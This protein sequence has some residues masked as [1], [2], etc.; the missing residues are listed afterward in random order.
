MGGGALF[1]RLSAQA[2]TTPVS[3]KPGSGSDG[4]LAQVVLG[5]AIYCTL[6]WRSILAPGDLIRD[7]IRGWHMPAAL[8]LVDSSPVACSSCSCSCVRKSRRQKKQ[9]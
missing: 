1:F 8:K 5:R 6:I 3:I 7:E 4:S 2:S 9:R